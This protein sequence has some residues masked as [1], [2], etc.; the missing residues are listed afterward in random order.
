MKASTRVIIVAFPGV[1]TL[2]AVG[3]AEVFATASRQLLI[4][5]NATSVSPAYRVILASSDGESARTTCGFKLTTTRLDRLRLSAHDTVLIA[6]GEEEAIVSALAEIKLIRWIRRAATV[7]GRIGSVCSGAFLL[8]H[9][10]VLDGRRAATHWA[11]CERLARFRASVNV[12]PNAIYVRDGRVWTS[13]GVTTGIDMALAMVEDDYGRALADK[14]ATR[15][16]L[17]ARRSGF[18][19][20]FSDALLAQRDDGDPL[21]AVLV[22]ARSHLCDLDPSKLA[23]LAGMSERTLHRRSRD[24]FGVTPARL[25]ARLRVEHAR[26]LL[27]TTRRTF[28]SIARECGFGGNERMRRSF[29]REIGIRPRDVRLLSGAKSTTEVDR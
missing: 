15:L 26:L 12:D 4:Q 11:S 3:P 25:V 2:D 13:A 10:G 8:A 27:A 20:Q 1:Q 28:D 14:V 7:A 21:G 29:E 17:Y 24:A 19:S 9:A 22:R 5:G 23:K 6:G 16:V 18:Q